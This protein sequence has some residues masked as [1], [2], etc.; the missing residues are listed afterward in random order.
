MSDGGIDAGTTPIAVTSVSPDR[1]PIAGGTMVMVSGTGFVDGATVV[2]G[3]AAAPMVTFESARRL[4]VV[5]PPVPEGRASV[6]V[7]NPDGRQATLPAAFLFEGMNT[8]TIADAVASNPAT[9][10]D[11][12]GVN[13]LR[14]LV[15]GEVKVLGRTDTVGPP[16]GV[17]AQVGF[18][19]EGS[20]NFTWVDAPWLEDSD[21]YDAFQG[22][23][24]VPTPM[25][26]TVATYVLGVRF[27]VTAGASWVE[28]DRDGSSVNGVTDAQRPRIT[29]SR[30]VIEWCKLG[31]EQIDPP[32]SLDLRIGQQGPLVFGQVFV[33]GVTNASGAGNGVQG[34][35]GIGDAGTPVETW[36]WFPAMYNRDT[37]A[38]ANDEHMVAMPTLPELAGEKRFAFRF[39]L[40]GGPWRYCDADGIATTGFTEDQTGRVR[41]S[42]ATIDECRLQFPLSLMSRQGVVAGTVYGR[43]LSVGITEAMGAGAG[44]EAQL[45]VGPSTSLPSDTWNWVPATYNVD[46]AGGQEEWQADLVGPAPGTYAYAYRFRVQGGPWRYCDSDPS[47]MMIQAAQL[48]ALTAQSSTFKAIAQCKLQFVD[49][50]TVPSGDAVVAFG[51]VSV[52]GFSEGAGATPGL[53]GEVGVGTQGSNASTD[54]AWGWRPATYFGEI[55]DAGEDEFSVTFTPAYSGTRAVSFRFAVDDGG[56]SYC[57]LNGSNVGGY[58]VGQQHALTVERSAVPYCVLQFP[59]VA[60]AGQTIYGQVYVPGVTRDAGAPITAELGWGKEIEDPGVSSQWTWVPATYNENCPGCGNNNE[61]EAVLGSRD[62]G[63]YAFRFRYGAN[64]CYADLDGSGSILPMSIGGFNGNGGSNLGQ[65]R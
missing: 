46:V 9:A 55:P 19:P 43:V 54:P 28:G 58:E 26:M 29:V 59:P 65:A 20:T 45:G 5:T 23:V 24:T 42:S 57:D 56:W 47:D 15:K 2:F 12:T 53:R 39:G 50:S 18:A 1:G 16:M 60:D 34:Q 31:G 4:V 22:S 8:G 52:P 51:R 38:A 13:P 40:N 14:I 6:T 3:T 21:L 37:G 36:S 10:T 41:L 49:R 17:V 61:Y 32:P 35:L 48:G 63:A 30:P 11:T 62:G 33:P 64:T 25:G 44:I 7:V 27:S